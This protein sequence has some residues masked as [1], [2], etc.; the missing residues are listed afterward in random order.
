MSRALVLGGGGP[1]GIAWEAGLIV[2]LADKGISLADADEVIGTSA[3]S[4]VGAQLRLPG[5][6]GQLSEML[7]DAL[8][9]LADVSTEA[10][11]AGMQTLMAVL[12]GAPFDQAHPEEGRARVGRVALEA[13]TM[14]EEHFVQLFSHLSGVDWPRGFTCTA[15][16][17]TS[18]E[19]VRWDHRTGAELQRAVA[20]SCAV[21]GVFPAV[22]IEGRRYMDGGIRTPLNADL[23]AGHDAVVAVSC[24]TLRLPEGLSDPVFDRMAAQIDAELEAVNASGARLGVVAPGEEFLEISGWGL[25]LMDTSRVTAALDAGIRQGGAE[26]ERLKATWLE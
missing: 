5:D 2:G 16:D 20:S 15:V 11:N 12:A 21:P 26:A 13:Q 18:G 17:T 4:V 14:P 22:T 8:A 9:R 23:A 1:V 10:I 7:G 25:Y 24:M 19:F 3:G 6:L